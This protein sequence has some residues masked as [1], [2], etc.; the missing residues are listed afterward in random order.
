MEFYF[1]MRQGFFFPHRGEMDGAY[2]FCHGKF[3]SIK[4]VVVVFLGV[5]LFRLSVR[6]V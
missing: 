6:M 2:M 5:S 1:F 3:Q 4:V